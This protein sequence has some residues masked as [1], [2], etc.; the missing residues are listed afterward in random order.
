[1]VK[2]LLDISDYDGAEDE[3]FPPLPPPHSPSLGGQEE[4]DPFTN[5]EEEGDVSKLD[6]VPAAKRK[7]VKRPQ[8]KLDSNRLTSERGLPALRTLFDNVHFKGKGHEAE[9]LRLLMQK[10]EN[11][12]HRLFPKLQF[13]DFI[14]KVEKLGNKKEVQVGRRCC[15][16]IFPEH[17]IISCSAVFVILHLLW[18]PWQ[19]CLKRIRLD[20]PLTH[21][22]FI[23]EEAA[24]P[25][26]HIFGDP[27]PFSS[28]SF[29]DELPGPVHSTPAPAAP[30]TP[31]AAPSLTEEQRKRMELNRQRALERRLARQQQ[32]PADMS[33]SQPA[34]TSLLEDGPSAV[35]VH[36]NSKDQEEKEEVEEEE[37]KEE[38]DFD[39]QQPASS[40][41][42]ADQ[43]PSRD[44]EP[45]EQ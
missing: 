40:S 5:G 7:G 43:L 35:P 3:A 27:D 12:A 32:Q 23:G 22:D 4:G 8:P 25:E 17:F 19:T 28:G 26:S 41:T 15:C 16:R 14:D 9:D 36:N 24:A 6:E 45:S 20:M 37:K 18:S 42:Q 44:S 34:D 38:E 31:D 33:D 39:L 30:P 13:E 29:S 21:E 2:G 1:M 11:W 10:M